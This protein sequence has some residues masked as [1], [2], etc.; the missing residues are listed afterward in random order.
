MRLTYGELDG[1]WSSLYQCGD[2]ASHVFYALQ[3]VVLVE[4]AVVD[5]NVKAVARLRVEQ[6]LQAESLHKAQGKCGKDSVKFYVKDVRC[7]CS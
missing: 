6:A 3:E 7:R 5:G 4:K 2:G 1:I